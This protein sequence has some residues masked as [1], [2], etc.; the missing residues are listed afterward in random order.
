MSAFRPLPALGLCLVT[1]ACTPIFND[2]FE[3]DPANGAPLADPPGAPA[4][5][6]VETGAGQGS[7]YVTTA[8]PLEGAQSLKLEGPSGNTSPRVFLRAAP[9]ADQTKP[10]FLSWSGRLASG[11]EVEIVIVKVENEGVPLRLNFEQG[12]VYANG[13]SIG[14]YTGTSPHGVFVSLNPT[15]GQWGVTLSGGAAT[16][17]GGTASGAFPDPSDFPAFHLVMTAQL[18]NASGTSGYWMDNVK[19]SHW[20]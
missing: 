12:I 1:A 3:A 15:T 5:D 18:K 19:M 4:G 6:A 13:N 8:L 17:G 16:N 2:T 10:V 20:K 14:S 11:A 9:I 7:I